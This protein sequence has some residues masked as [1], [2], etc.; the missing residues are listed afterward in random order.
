M[1]LWVFVVPVYQNYTKRKYVKFFPRAKPLFRSK[2]R[3]VMSKQKEWLLCSH[4]NVEIK[5]RMKS[6]LK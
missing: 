2:F 3:A 1:R 5:K 6:G 4:K